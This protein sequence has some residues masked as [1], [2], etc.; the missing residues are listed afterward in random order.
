MRYGYK[1]LTQGSSQTVRIFFALWPEEHIRDAIIDRRQQLG[2]LTRR[3]VPDH[4]LH[5]TLLFLGNQRRTVLPELKRAVDVIKADTF[6]L[7]LNEFGW[8]RMPRVAWLGGAAVE[9][10]QRL[11]DALAATCTTL[12][13]GYR[14]NPWNPHVTLYRQ[15]QTKPVFPQPETIFWPVSSYVLLESIPNK[16]YKIL[17]QWALS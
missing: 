15:V 6:L 16:P 2:Q 8:F 17:Y 11:V 5:L 4:N 3:K 9:A 10:G 13:M 7:K 14:Q 12:G 1:Q